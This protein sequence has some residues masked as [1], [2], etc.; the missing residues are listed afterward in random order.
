MYERSAGDEGSKKLLVF[1]YELTKN[2]QFEGLGLGIVVVEEFL[3]LMSSHQEERN[4][5]NSFCI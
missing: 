2:I 3:D 4:L 1:R 5:E